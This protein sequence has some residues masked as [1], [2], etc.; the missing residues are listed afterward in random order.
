MIFTVYIVE[1]G[2]INTNSVIVPYLER[3]AFQRC[4]FHVATS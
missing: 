4:V 2:G 1:Q 3:V